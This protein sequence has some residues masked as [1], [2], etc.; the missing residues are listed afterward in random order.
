MK[1][2]FRRAGNDEVRFD[3]KAGYAL[4]EELG[5]AGKIVSI[6]PDDEPLLCY[7]YDDNFCGLI[8]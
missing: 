7:Y 6:G 8:S 2:I 1:F 5:L 4:L 3:D